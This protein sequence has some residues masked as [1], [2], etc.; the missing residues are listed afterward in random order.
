VIRSP[1]APRPGGSGFA[2]LADQAGDPQDRVIALRLRG[3][4]LHFLGE[5]AQSRRETERMLERYD[6]PPLRS[7]LIRFQYD[8]RLTA[9]IT[10]ARDLWL[11]GEGDQAL[12][13]IAEMVADAQ[14]LDHTLTLAH[15]LSDGA[16]FIALWSGDLALAERYTDL[17]R[18]QNHASRARRLAHLRPGL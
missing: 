18:A 1:R 13:L 12:A 3:R 8:Q 4:S 15:V 10:L 7:H 6:P 11:E 14:A 2:A 5:F 9:Q 17:L 16:C